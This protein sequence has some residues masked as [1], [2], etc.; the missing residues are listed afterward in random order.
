MVG[1]PLEMVSRPDGGGDI[2]RQMGAEVFE[3]KGLIFRVFPREGSSA[4]SFFGSPGVPD[5]L[6]IVFRA[7]PARRKC[8]KNSFWRERRTGWAGRT[9]SGPSGTPGAPHEDFLVHSGRRKGRT[10]YFW[11]ERHTGNAA[12][13][14]FAG[15][16]L[17]EMRVK[18]SVLV[19][20]TR[21][22]QDRVKQRYGGCH[23]A[24]A[25]DHATLSTGDLGDAGVESRTDG[26][27][28]PGFAVFGGEDERH[29]DQGERL[30]HGASVGGRVT[31]RLAQP[32]VKSQLVV[33]AVL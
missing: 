24:A 30:R 21:R 28:R 32:I 5:A 10:N 11:R 7:R 4:R 23:T 2:P 26:G 16:F 3:G 29:H 6:E 31:W 33:T 27:S 12:Q 8:C 25:A 15:S 14:F 9:F 1:T 13:R 18:V 22:K 20:L 19:A 17:P